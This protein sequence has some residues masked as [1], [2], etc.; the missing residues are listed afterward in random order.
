MNCNPLSPSAS[1]SPTATPTACASSTSPTGS[2]RRWCSR[3][4][5]CRRSRP[6]PSWRRPGCTCCWGRARTVKATCSTWARATPSAPGWRATMRKGFLDPRHR[7]HHHHGRAA[8]QGACAVSGVAPHR[9]GPRRQ[10][11]AAGQRQPA[12][13]AI[14][15]R[16]RPGRHGSLSW[17][18]CWA[19]C[20][21]WGCMRS[22]KRPKPQPP[23]RARVL[24]CKGK[25][26]AGHWLRGQPGFVVRA[27][28][29]RWPR[30]CAIHGAAC[31][32]HVSTCGRS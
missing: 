17:A 27:G 9:P 26:V 21:C 23:K 30:H 15:E 10:A 5:C 18:T 31:A 28:R 3:V 32:R 8:Q 25:G 11:H 6:G 2:A 19:C 13:R 16:G 20:R 1:S 24:T 7:L 22:S 12:R 4:R 14:T 29:R